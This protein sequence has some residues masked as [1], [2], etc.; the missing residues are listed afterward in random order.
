MNYQAL[1]TKLPSA[2]WYQDEEQKRVYTGFEFES[3]EQTIAFF[4][5]VTDMALDT[6]V[7]PDL[8]I[9][10]AK[11]LQISFKA[12]ENGEFS[13]KTPELM[14]AI[15]DLFNS[16]EQKVEVEEISATE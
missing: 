15:E 14:K 8:Y 16:L 3:F 4:D 6:E 5:E 2:E 9:Y 10:D 13:E 12:D 11:V 7:Y 1:I